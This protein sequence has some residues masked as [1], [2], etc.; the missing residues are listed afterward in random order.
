MVQFR[1][2]RNADYN[3]H[4]ACAKTCLRFHPDNAIRLCGQ[5][6]VFIN[7]CRCAFPSGQKIFH[8]P[9]NRF[10]GICR[11]LESDCLICFC[12][13]NVF[14]ALYDNHIF[15]GNAVCIFHRYFHRL[16][17]NRFP[18][19]DIVSVNRCSSCLFCRHLA[20]CVYGKHVRIAAGITDISHR[21]RYRLISV[22]CNFDI[23]IPV[24]QA[25]IGHTA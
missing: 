24:I 20:I 5:N 9:C 18:I 25:L 4:T 8:R 14:S 19:P 2:V 23:C 1:T 15:R 13:N 11:S 3:R 6:S 7:Y 10:L 12:Q 21:C 16:R 22:I 17:K